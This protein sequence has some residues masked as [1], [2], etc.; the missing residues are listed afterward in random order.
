MFILVLGASASGKSEYAENLCVKLAKGAQKLYVATMEPYGE[1]AAFRIKRHRTL[2]AKKGF[3]TLERYCDL[4]DCAFFSGADANAMPCNGNAP[5][6]TPDSR[7]HTHTGSPN[8]GT[9]PT[10]YHT[11]LLECMSTLLANEYFCEGGAA[12]YQDK[13]TNGIALLRAHSDNLVLISN[14]ICSDGI[15]YEP[16]TMAYLRVLA[17]LNTTLA[18][19]ADAVIEVTCGIPRILK[20]RI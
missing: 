4:A 19:Q 2:R 14:K 18:Q 7:N 5:T 20:G 9:N 17:S 12:T 10:H 3:D 15:A 11:I 16:T 6:A 13:I 1:D 8:A